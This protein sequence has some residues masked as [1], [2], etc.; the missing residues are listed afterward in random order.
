M[1]T[2]LDD[3]SVEAKESTSGHYCHSFAYFWF[4]NHYS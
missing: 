1:I 4:S 3:L 2:H